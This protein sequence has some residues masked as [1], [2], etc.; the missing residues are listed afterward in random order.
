M[1]YVRVSEG[2][3][4][5]GTLVPY[6]GESM[7]ALVKDSNKDYYRSVFLY[8]QDHYNHFQKNHSV[9]GITDVY[10]KSLVFD[11]DDV[12]NPD[13]AQSSAME[14]CARLTAAGVKEDEFVVAFSGNKGFSVE[15]ETDHHFTPEQA[16]AIAFGLAKD[17]PTFDT[18]MYNASRI[19][20]MRNTRHNKTSLF[21][22]PV[23]V[24]ELSELTIDQIK[25]LAKEK[26][27]NNADPYVV[28]LPDSIL[29]YGNT[30]PKDTLVSDTSELPSLDL[31]SKPK[32]MPACKFA[33]LHGFFKPGNRNHSLM[34]LAAHYKAQG[35][36]KEVT[37]RILKGSA[38]LQAKRFNQDAYSKEEI[39]SNIIGT[40]YGPSWQGKTYAC[41]DHEFLQDVCPKRANGTTMC[42]AE[43][44]DTLVTIETVSETFRNYAANIDK[45]TIKTGIKPID[46]QI[47]LQTH[48]HVI[49]AGCS[50]SGKTSLVLN[51]LNNA[52]RMGVKG[53]FGS[54]DMSSQLIYQKLAHKVTGFDDKKLYQIY[55]D[56]DEKKIKEIDRKIS[57]EYKNIFFDFRS[58]VDIDELR[59]NLMAVKEKHGSDLKI[60]VFDFINRIRGPYSDETANLAYIAPRLAD[61]ANET[62]TLIISLAQVGRAKGGPATPLQDSRVAKGS[63]AI[64]ES[65]T[66]LLGLW[67]PG[68]NTNSDKFI[69][70]AALKTRM[71][72]E[73]SSGL[74]WNGLTGEIRALS[75][76]EEIELD[77]LESEND[78]QEGNGGF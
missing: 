14:L 60:A 44:K 2:L 38:E 78:E 51:I 41:K 36:P 23:T 27:S 4:D 35:V 39:W 69:R 9:A 31:S 21:K 77:H 53:V 70:I 45:N 17:L 28:E 6:D 63:S 1:E 68:Y 34:A 26:T 22:I 29:N 3:N 12:D 73:F 58:G 32:N 47:R 7:L 57:E 59:Q 43:K 76:D 25:T 24:K 62:E 72:K 48:S 52:S 5:R 71:G 19:F 74:Y 67:R 49:L 10:T 66:V 46:D 61:L 20:R 8:N 75:H 33:I 55:K 40:V 65:A 18:K 37:Y 50:G 42:S 54:M 16:K 13:R 56:N 15:L 30:K 11:F 64:E